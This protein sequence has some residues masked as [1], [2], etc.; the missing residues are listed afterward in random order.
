MGDSDNRETDEHEPEFSGSADSDRETLDPARSQSLPS[1]A[2]LKLIRSYQ[3]LSQNTPAMCR[4]YPT[5]SE[6]T[7]QAIVKYGFVKGSAMG[8]WRICRCHPFSEGGEDPVP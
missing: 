1:R 6:Y 2:A 4:F 7:R 3:K 8:A 5:C